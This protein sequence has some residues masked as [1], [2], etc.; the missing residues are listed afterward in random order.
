MDLE[1][2]KSDS[3]K[4]ELD[5]K[6]YTLAIDVGSVN[7]GY[8]LYNGTNISLN[9]LNIDDKIKSYKFEKGTE[10]NVKR[11]KILNDW[12]NDLLNFYDIKTVVI[13]KQVKNNVK[14]MLIQSALI[15]LVTVHDIK[16]KSYDPK[17][18]F[19]YEKIEFD[20]KKKEHKKI[21]IH[22]AYNILVNMNLSTDEFIQFKKKDDISDALCMAVMINESDERVKW[23]INDHTN[24]PLLKN[25]TETIKFKKLI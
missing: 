2:S 19:R 23:L 13:E 4:S 5:S 6:P 25:K 8:A 15:T 3:E 22:Y 9:I 18:K 17:N 16:F 21:S 24:N 1:K 10:I 11:V 14:C 7:L 12:F 20:S